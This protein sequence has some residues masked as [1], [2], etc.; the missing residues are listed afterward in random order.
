MWWG[1]GRWEKVKQGKKNNP[2]TKNLTFKSDL[3]TKQKSEFYKS[4][5]KMTMQSETIPKRESEIVFQI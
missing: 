4:R 3:K 1:R 5:I 2:T